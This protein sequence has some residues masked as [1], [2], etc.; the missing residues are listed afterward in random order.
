[1]VKINKDTIL[2]IS[3]A[4]KPSNLGTAI[5]NQAYKHLGLNFIYKACA[6]TDAKA[7]I[8]GVRALGIRGCSVSMPHK[9]KVIEYLDELDPVAKEIGAVNTIVNTHG[10][11]KGYNSDAHGFESVLHDLQISPGSSVLVLGGGGV[12]K[13]ILYILK[14]N[15]F[16]SV[17]IAN[18]NRSRA[19]ELAKSYNFTSINWGDR[20]KSN[21]DFLIN[22]TSIGMN[23]NSDRSPIKLKSV[24]KYSYIF[25]V[26]ISPTETLLISEAKR[27]NIV[28][29][30]GYRMTLYA[31]K[32]QFELYTGQKTPIE[33]MEKTILELL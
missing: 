16:N 8:Q 1:M 5:H 27:K 21:F 6:V 12:A 3:I 26:V 24:P 9:E 32:M 11:L 19:E 18:R 4:S 10:K 14:K 29:R 15:K 20:E 28:C 33:V 31:A 17:S 22:A 30:P 2:C 25:D 7:A 23:P 13:A